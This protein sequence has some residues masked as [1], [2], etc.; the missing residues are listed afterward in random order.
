M[1][2]KKHI[3]SQLAL[4]AVC[5]GSVS[6]ASA[7]LTLDSPINAGPSVIIT[8]SSSIAGT[9]VELFVNDVSQGSTVSDGTTG[10]FDFQVPVAENDEVHVTAS[11]VWNFNNDGDAEGWYSGTDGSDPDTIT[12][13]NGYITYTNTNTDANIT[14]AYDNPVLSSSIQRV[15]EIRYRINSAG[16]NSSAQ[17]SFYQTSGGSFINFGA[18]QPLQS[19]GQGQFTTAVFSLD[20]DQLTG[21]DNGWTAGDIVQLVW[22]SNNYA[23]NDSID[24]DYI[25]LT[26]YFDFHF[27]NDGDTM[28]F[29]A[30]DTTVVEDGLLK[31][32]SNT[33]SN[34]PFITYSVF[35]MLDTSYFTV[36]EFAVSDLDTVSTGPIN[37]FTFQALGNTAGFPVAGYQQTYNNDGT[38]QT[39]FID[40]SGAATFGINYQ[41]N[42]TVTLNSGSTLQTFFGQTGDSVE[43]DYF[44]LRPAGT[45]SPSGTELVGPAVANV[46]DWQT[47][48]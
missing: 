22:G 12:V 44:R 43:V 2:S 16:W 15:A 36:A 30:S 45:L 32:T 1:M 37:L 17:S 7:Q 41:D 39:A 14:F 26:E 38:P 19:L 25:R 20:R 28:S 46:H 35:G 5:A 24:I 10:D 34:N 21:N 9:P 29:F 42:P 40:L 47:F 3:F 8:G 33:D 23:L 11:V 48:E 31:Q 4:V 27:N 18:I 6:V 13:Q